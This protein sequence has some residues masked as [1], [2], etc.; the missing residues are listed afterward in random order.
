MSE[1]FHT[2]GGVTSLWKSP[3][4]MPETM[5]EIATR[6]ANRHDL[7]LKQMTSRC[8]ERTFAWPRQE[9]AWEM[10]QRDRWS[11]PQ[12]ALTLGWTNHTTA[13]HAIR[14]HQKRLD[15]AIE[16]ERAA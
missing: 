4:S 13:M 9:A 8:R 3:F 7:T 10:A 5:R 12:I 1:P 2:G 11:L 6:V 14:A 16:A 15:A